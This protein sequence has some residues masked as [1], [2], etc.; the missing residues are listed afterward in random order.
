MKRNVWADEQVAA[1]INKAS[2]PVMIDVDDPNAAATMSRYGVGAP[3][4][5][6]VIDSQGTV[7]QQRQ[8]GMDK[9]EFLEMLEA[10]S[11]FAAK[12]R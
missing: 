7:L 11:S 5:T 6:T 8:G 2:V 1:A 9:A 3:P 4:N 12:D 10:L